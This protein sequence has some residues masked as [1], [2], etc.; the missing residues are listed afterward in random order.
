AIAATKRASLDMLLE[1]IDEQL[2]KIA[3]TNGHFT[4]LPQFV[5]S[6]IN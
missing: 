1:R 6:V 5:S 4:E 2:G 3:L